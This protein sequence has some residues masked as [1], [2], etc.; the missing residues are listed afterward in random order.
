MVRAN[1]NR[2]LSVLLAATVSGLHIFSMVDSLDL[3][4]MWL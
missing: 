2:S 1:G 3:A 4:T